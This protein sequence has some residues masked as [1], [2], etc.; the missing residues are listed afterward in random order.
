MGMYRLQRVTGLLYRVPCKIMNL[1]AG[2]KMD[3]LTSKGHVLESSIA[4]PDFLS[5]MAEYTVGY[6]ACVKTN[7]PVESK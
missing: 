7:E 5:V 1:P 2:S 4:T 6:W 3:V